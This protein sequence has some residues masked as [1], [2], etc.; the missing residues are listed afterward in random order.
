MIFKVLTV[1]QGKIAALNR[2]DGKLKIPV[3]GLYQE[4]KNLQT[5]MSTSTYHRKRGH[6]FFWTQCIWQFYEKTRRLV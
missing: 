1:S 6:M 4:Y 3:D 2:F 5:G